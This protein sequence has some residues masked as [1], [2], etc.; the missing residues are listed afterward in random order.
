[1]NWRAHH[2]C[3]N[4]IFPMMSPIIQKLL[5]HHHHHHH[6]SWLL[7]VIGPLDLSRSNKIFEYTIS[8]MFNFSLDI[9]V[10]FF[11]YCPIRFVCPFSSYKHIFTQPFSK[12]RRR[13][14][15]CCVVGPAN[16]FRNSFGSRSGWTD[17]TRKPKKKN[18]VDK[19][20][21]CWLLLVSLALPLLG[22]GWYYVASIPFHLW[23][24]PLPNMM[25]I[26]SGSIHSSG[27]TIALSYPMGVFKR[28]HPRNYIVCR[29]C[30]FLHFLLLCH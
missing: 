11:F 22:V 20:M 18:V 2:Q 25:I 14:G 1:M 19:F 16:K 21:D 13:F 9:Q 6:S 10:S 26:R 15:H 4:L 5:S 17:D 23:S 28:T 8:S 27:D 7:F 12:T 3:F 30:L 29:V 24:Q